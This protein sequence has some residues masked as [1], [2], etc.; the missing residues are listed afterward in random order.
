[1][2]RM[3][4]KYERKGTNET[5]EKKLKV[6]DHIKYEIRRTT[7]RKA[8]RNKTGGQ[9]EPTERS[10]EKNTNRGTIGLNERTAK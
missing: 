9:N 2:L 1:M 8:S 6:F 7:E 5:K 10:G 4:A 3:K